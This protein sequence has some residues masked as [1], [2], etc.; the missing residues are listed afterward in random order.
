MALYDGSHHIT[1]QL[2]WQDDELVEIE[3]RLLADGWCGN[4]TAYTTL[5][6]I[7]GFAG[8]VARFA[9]HLSGE[10]KLQAGVGG[11]LVRMHFNTT[12]SAGHVACYLE[13]ESTHGHRN[14]HAGKIAMSVT[15]EPSFIEAFARSLVRMANEEAGEAVLILE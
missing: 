13:L 5:V 4:S 3:A 2:I 12:D 15:T 10:A 7:R 9:L 11:D 6:E 1:V 8:D 14:A